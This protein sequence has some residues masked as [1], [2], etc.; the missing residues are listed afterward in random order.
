VPLP[1]IGIA[2]QVIEVRTSKAGQVAFCESNPSHKSCQPDE[3]E[4]TNSCPD[5]CEDAGSVI[6]SGTNSL[7]A[8]VT[9]CELV[10]KD[11]WRSL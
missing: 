3:C 1:N 10:K 6:I 7:G 8:G 2:P 4:L 5:K 9:R 11:Y